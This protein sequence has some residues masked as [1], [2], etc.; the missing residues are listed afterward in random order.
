MAKL[1]DFR[2]LFTTGNLIS[3]GSAMFI[4]GMAWM[5]VQSTQAHQATRLDKLD[6]SDKSITSDVNTIKQDIAVI[7]NV[8]KNTSDQITEV[9]EWLR[10]ISAQLHK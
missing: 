3:G 4:A 9:K 2:N 6:E 8:Q 7:K 5:N 10:I 1:P